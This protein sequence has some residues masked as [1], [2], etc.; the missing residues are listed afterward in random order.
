MH[1]GNIKT[2]YQQMLNTISDLLSTN[3]YK[4][5]TKLLLTV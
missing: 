4:E 2:D 5:N 1:W 3:S